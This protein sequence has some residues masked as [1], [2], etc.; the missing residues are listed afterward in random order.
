MTGKDLIIVKE[1]TNRSITIALH[2]LHRRTR[3]TIILWGAIKVGLYAP[4]ALN[5]YESYSFLLEAESTKLT[6]KKITN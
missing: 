1:N 5:P 2:L 3:P 6:E 4:T